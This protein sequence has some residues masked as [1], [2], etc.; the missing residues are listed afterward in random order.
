MKRTGD[1]GSDGLTPP[2]DMIAGF[3]TADGMLV[4]NDRQRII[5]WNEAAESMLGY[6]ADEAIGRPC[7]ELVAGRDYQ[8][9]PF[10]RQNCAVARNARK[11]RTVPDYEVLANSRCG[12]RM[13]VNVS[14]I[15]L[16]SAQPGPMLLHLFRRPRGRVGGEPL[17]R[18]VTGRPTGDGAGNPW[19]VRPLSRRESEVV[20]ML[21]DGCTTQEIAQALTISPL[22]ARNHIGNIM[23]K[24]GTR[25]RL[26]AVIV[27]ARHGLV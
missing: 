7:Y 18:Q 24:L 17:P 9:N 15:A 12:E 1:S 14:T 20:R 23:T 8:A 26:E 13:W 25:S 4:T 6:T 27:A 19:P 10:C 22:T 3:R 5:H 21:S 16:P 11:G 2:F